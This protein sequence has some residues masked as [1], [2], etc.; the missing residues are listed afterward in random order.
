MSL[1]QYYQSFIALKKQMETLDPSYDVSSLS[2]KVF[3]NT[4]RWKEALKGL[5][6]S[7]EPQEWVLSEKAWITYSYL[8]EIGADEKERTELILSAA[9]MLVD[10]SDTN[11]EARVRLGTLIHLFDLSEID[12]KQENTKWLQALKLQKENPEIFYCLGLYYYLHQGD[13]KKGQNCIEKA[14]ILKPNF[15]EAQYML[16]VIL[17]NNNNFSKAL[18]IIEEIEKINRNLPFTY[19][20]KGIHEF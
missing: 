15:F 10:A 14:I 20:F 7:K 2:Y 6:S 16:C 4:N 17:I 3:I 5:E 13:L 1:E 19:L 18:E 11:V 12:L 9:K 8:E